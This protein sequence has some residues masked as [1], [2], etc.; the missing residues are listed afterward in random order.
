MATIILDVDG[1]LVD[2][3]YQHALAWYRAFRQHGYVLPVWRLHRHQGMGGDQFVAAVAGKQA[4][5]ECG[6]AIRE[7]EGKYYGELIDEVSPLAGARELLEKLHA[8]DWTSVL[9]SSA[10][11]EELDHYLDLLD[12]RELVA[13]WTGAG[14]VKETK[15]KPDLIHVAL[16]KVGSSSGLMVGDSVFDCEAAARAGIDSVALLTGGFSREELLEAGAVE[17]FDTL[18]KLGEWLQKR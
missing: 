3:N 8:G 14:D 4:E 1:T 17:V 11:P 16:E 7:A 5:E 12:A 9:A 18:D 15:P 10:K 2:T 13:A 6:D